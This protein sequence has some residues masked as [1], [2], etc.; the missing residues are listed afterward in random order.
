MR[1]SGEL[2]RTTELLQ[3]RDTISTASVTGDDVAVA[4]ASLTDAANPLEPHDAF[5]LAVMRRLDIEGI[6]TNDHDFRSLPGITA[7]SFGMPPRHV[8]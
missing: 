4:L 8:W 3:R 6:A 1:H 5:H 2:V 7:L